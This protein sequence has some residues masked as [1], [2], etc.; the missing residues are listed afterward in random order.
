M[1]YCSI[2][3]GIVR[4]Y[5][6]SDRSY[7]GLRKYIMNEKWSDTDPVPWYKSPTSLQLVTW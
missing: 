1:F 4:E 7:G 5:S 2:K 3:D 6:G